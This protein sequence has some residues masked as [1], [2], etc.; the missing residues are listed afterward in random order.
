MNKLERIIEEKKTKSSERRPRYGTRKLAVGM[1]SCVL[2]Y[3]VFVSSPVLKAEKVEVLSGDEVAIES[4]E[5]KAITRVTDDLNFL[6]ESGSKKENILAEVSDNAVVEDTVQVASEAVQKGTNVETVK[7]E[8]VTA[9]ENENNIL[10]PVEEA[11]QE[12]STKKVQDEAAEAEETDETQK[13]AVPEESAEEVSEPENAEDTIPM[14]EEKSEEAKTPVTE[15]KAEEEKAPVTEEKIE[16][17]VETKEA[18]EV[19]EAEKEDAEENEEEAA[20]KDE[21]VEFALT[22]AQKIIYQEDI[23]YKI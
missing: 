7:E 1:V 5:D 15:E 19:S 20:D 12:V 4:F 11:A 23:P 13:N 6:A 3:M 9:E 16:E 22:E 17:P 8:S 18:E 14:A 21:K 2:G 10:A